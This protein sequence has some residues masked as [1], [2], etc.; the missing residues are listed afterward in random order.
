MY[1]QSHEVRATAPGTQSGSAFR[2]DG[3]DRWNLRDFLYFVRNNALSM[4]SV[5]VVR[6]VVSVLPRTYALRHWVLLFTHATAA[7][8]MVL[9]RRATSNRRN[10]CNLG[11]HFWNRSAV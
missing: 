7:L 9:A 1:F 11:D 4:A 3:V 10:P 8:G 2:L 5:R 6:A